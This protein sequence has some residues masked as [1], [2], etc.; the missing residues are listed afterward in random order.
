VGCEPTGHRWRI[1]AELCDRLGLDLVCVQPLLVARAREQEDLT[2]AKS[3]P[4][5]A[6]LIARL[7]AGLRCY[8]PE[9]ADQVWARLRQLGARRAQL[10]TQ[11]TAARQQ[12]GDLL[13]CAWPAVL[14]AAAKPLDS[15]TFR[16]AVSVVLARDQGDPAGLH[17]L[18]YARFGRQVTRQLARWG[19]QRRCQRILRAVWT[20]AT[21][22][23]ALALGVSS[24]RLGALERASLILEDW[25]HA[26]GQLTETNRRMTGVLDQ[27]QLTGLVTSIPGLSVVGAAAILAET[28]DPT[29]FDSA[30]ALVKH[31]GLCP[32]DNQSGAHAGTTPISGRAGPPCGWPPGGPPGV[33]WLTTRSPK[34]ATPTSPAAPTT[35]SPPP[36]P[37]PRW[38]RPCS[39]GCG[40]WSP[41]APAGRPPSPP[42]PSTPQGGD[43]P[44]RLRTADNGRGELAWALGTTPRV[45]MSSPARLPPSSDTGRWAKPGCTLGRAGETGQAPPTAA[46]THTHTRFTRPVHHPSSRSRTP[47]HPQA[48][49]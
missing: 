5:D 36:R 45:S 32:R 37:A 38:P 22:R 21:S 8:V 23:K 9:R 43:R 18:G 44:G 20:A 3:D 39:D 10:T 4:K 49:P 41:S 42:A 14:Q 15:L 28:G 46:T 26:L 7:V 2:G 35:S 30:R 47:I 25:H 33:R 31:A 17:R 34:P 16:A 6:V 13:E 48:R 24:Q 29:R 40:W 11:V 1:V 27:L 12:L 19:G